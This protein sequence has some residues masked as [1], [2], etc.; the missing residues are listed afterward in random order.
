MEH[1]FLD[2][3]KQLPYCAL[4]IALVIIFLKQMGARDKRNEEMYD[5]HIQAFHEVVK[6]NS[7]AM[8]EAASS[9]T[10]LM[11]VVRELKDRL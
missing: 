9:R 10:E 3:M 8:K 7:S 11:V 1:T 2:A 4:M 6:E 5:K